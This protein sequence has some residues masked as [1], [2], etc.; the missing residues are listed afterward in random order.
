MVSFSSS[1]LGSCYIY[2]SQSCGA[3][4]VWGGLLPAEQRPQTGTPAPLDDAGSDLAA[5][6]YTHVHTQYTRVNAADKGKR[7]DILKMQFIQITFLQY[8][9]PVKLNQKI[10]S[11]N[12]IHTIAAFS[13]PE[14][15]F[16]QASGH[17][18]HVCRHINQQGCE[19]A[20]SPV[21]TCWLFLMLAIR[22]VS[23]WRLKSMAP[24]PKSPKINLKGHKIL[25]NLINKW[26]TEYVNPC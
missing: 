14:S 4:S 26:N 1:R 23:I 9:Y 19:Y 10:R 16:E 8:L 15:V 20:V 11:L 5:C 17:V 3:G 25:N 7:A 21:M 13:S 12:W 22:I 18:C 2:S 24:T 6:R